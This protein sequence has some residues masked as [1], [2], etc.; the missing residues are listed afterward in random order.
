VSGRDDD[1]L[2]GAAGVAIEREPELFF[3]RREDRRQVCPSQPNGRSRVGS[4]RSEGEHEIPPSRKPCLI[5]DN[6]A[7]ATR[8]ESAL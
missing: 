4:E 3:D 1:V 6:V 2:D 8:H 7:L 5:D